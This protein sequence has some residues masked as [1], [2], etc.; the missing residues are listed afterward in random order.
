MN[1][2]ELDLYIK[3]VALYYGYESQAQQCIEEMAELTQAIV[4]L[5]RKQGNGQPTKGSAEE[6]MNNVVE[7]LAD[8]Q[9]MI[10]QLIYLLDVDIMPIIKSKIERTKR[11]M[12]KK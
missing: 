6:C 7:E 1:E 11:R 10:W 2:K 8:V 5:W 3:E 4:K 9:F 12:K